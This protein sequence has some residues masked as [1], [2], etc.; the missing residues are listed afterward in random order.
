MVRFFHYCCV[1][2][3]PILLVWGAFNLREGLEARELRS[4]R[5]ADLEAGA[6]PP[7]RWLKLSGKLLS[8]ERVI[9]DGVRPIETYVALVSED[10]RP[11]QP[12]VVFVRTDDAIR[13]RPGKLLHHREENVIGVGRTRPLPEWVR[14]SFLYND[15]KPSER[16][17]ILDFEAK[18]G[19]ELF[20]GGVALAAGLVLA[21]TSWLMWRRSG[22][23]SKGAGEAASGVTSGTEEKQP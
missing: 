10:W 1:L 9:W 4:M 22:H 15:L 14:E 6:S 8:E 19:D 18:P 2:L 16:P 13:D 5:V 21:A 17:L 12:I 23:L 3:S 7:G 11:G 20:F